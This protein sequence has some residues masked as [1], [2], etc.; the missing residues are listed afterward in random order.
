MKVDFSKDTRVQRLLNK[1]ATGRAT[2]M[3][4]WEYADLIGEMAAKVGQAAAADL[5]AMTDAYPAV[6]EF[7]EEYCHNPV[8]MYTQEVQAILNQRNGVNLKAV[9]SEFDKNRASGIAHNVA[10]AETE[11]E[12][13]QMMGPSLQN[14]TENTVSNTLADNCKLQSEFGLRPKVERIADPRCCE[15]CS[16]VAGSYYYDELPEESEIWR[17]HDRCRCTIQYSTGADF[18][19][20]VYKR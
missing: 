16:E 10:H 14:F 5:L 20:I 15:W 8:S 3:D 4:V 7:L 6:M 1:A 11:E 12:I 19:K 9:G 2:Y 18:K 17:R 13:R